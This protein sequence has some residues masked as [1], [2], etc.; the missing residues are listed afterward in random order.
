[1]S[2]G[3]PPNGRGFVRIAQQLQRKGKTG[4]TLFGSN[5]D[6][7]FSKFNAKCRISVYANSVPDN[8]CPRQSKALRFWQSFA[9]S[10]DWALFS[11]FCVD[12][13]LA[14]ISFQKLHATGE[15]KKG[16]CRKFVCPRNRSLC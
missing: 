12:L 1:V 3:A 9:V 5:V 2:A 16:I 7:S 6:E 13:N 4:K 14:H 11:S 15:K 10:D 8:M